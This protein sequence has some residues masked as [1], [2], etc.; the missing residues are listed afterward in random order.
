MA[1]KISVD[2]IKKS[3][4]IKKKIDST[5]F[6]KVNVVTESSLEFSSEENESSV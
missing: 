4:E 1:Y 6:S 2:K 3:A 5:T